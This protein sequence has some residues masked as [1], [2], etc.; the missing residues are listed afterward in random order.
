ML[1]YAKRI[2][3]KKH[4]VLTFLERSADPVYTGWPLV[5]G[6]MK[7]ESAIIPF[8]GSTI[9]YKLRT[10]NGEEDY[11]S[12]IRSYGWSVVFGVTEDGK[13]PTL[14]QWKP[15]VNCASWE[16]PPGGIG[17]LGSG[18]TLQEIADRTR[19]TYLAETGY[20]NGSWSSLGKVAIET[21]KF[22]GASPDDHGLFA[23]LFLATGLQQ[24]QEKKKPKGKRDHGNTH[25]S[26]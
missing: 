24:M 15:G 7:Q 16:L 6:S 13:V 20:G 4:S 14:I 11:T 2:Q 18:A 3:M 8:F 19:D 12:I 10:P 23:H 5:E 9:D 22:R 17:K 25:G 1:L 21:G 26:G